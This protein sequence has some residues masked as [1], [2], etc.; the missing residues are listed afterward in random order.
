MSDDSERSEEITPEQT[1]I[2]E[3]NEE[4]FMLKRKVDALT[5]QLK[6]LVRK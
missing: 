2:L 6:R 3:L 4:L 5:K 1:A